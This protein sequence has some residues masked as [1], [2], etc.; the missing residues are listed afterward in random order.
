MARNIELTE[1]NGY[2]DDLDVLGAGLI[3]VSREV[4]NV[5]AQ[6]G[7]VAQDSVQV[8]TGSLVSGM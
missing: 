6:R 2:Y 1:N 4:G 7:I 8:C 3:G 5:Q